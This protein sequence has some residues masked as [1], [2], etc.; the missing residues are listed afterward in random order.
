MTPGNV[1]P[2]ISLSV[3]YAVAMV[4]TLIIYPFYPNQASIMT[5]IKALNWASYTLGLAIVGLEIGFILAYRFGWQINLAA[6]I[7]NFSVSV[8]LIPI[9]LIC[10]RETLSIVN[11]IGLMFCIFGLVLLNYRA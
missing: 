3:T 1:N 2:I 7:S 10:F 9:G 8:L 5:N 4:T 6:V 11:A